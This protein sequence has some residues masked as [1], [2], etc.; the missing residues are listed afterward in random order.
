MCCDKELFDGNG[1][2]RNGG[3]VICLD[4]FSRISSSELKKGYV[5]PFRIIRNIRQSMEESKEELS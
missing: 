3:D 1:R 4:C 5:S 2:F